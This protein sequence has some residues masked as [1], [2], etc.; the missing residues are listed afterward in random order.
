MRGAGRSPAERERGERGCCGRAQLGRVSRWERGQVSE[1]SEPPGP[2]AISFPSPVLLS[3]ALGRE[4]SERASRAR[5]PLGRGTLRRNWGHTLSAELS[6]ESAGVSPASPVLFSAF[7]D[8]RLNVLEAAVSFDVSWGGRNAGR[9]LP[10]L[11]TGW[12]LE[13]GGS[14]SSGNCRLKAE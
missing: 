5:R 13:P 8:P 6:G 10:S 9:V 11:V 12:Q 7:Y 3:S 1:V 2:G 14:P 4:G